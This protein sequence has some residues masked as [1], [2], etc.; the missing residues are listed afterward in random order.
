M[1]C[2]SSKS[3]IDH[4]TNAKTPMLCIAGEYRTVYEKKGNIKKVIKSFFKKISSM[5][6]SNILTTL[7]I[8]KI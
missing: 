2:L 5:I 7:K 4:K 1:K 6:N 8:K 3:E